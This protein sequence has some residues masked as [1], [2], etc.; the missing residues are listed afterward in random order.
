MRNYRFLHYMQVRQKKNAYFQRNSMNTESQY[1]L[2]HAAHDYE[3]LVNR[4]KR[5]ADSTSLHLEPFYNSDDLAHYFL[6]NEADSEGFYISAGIH[7]DEAAS[8]WGLL[9]WVEENANWIESQRCLI[10]PCLNPWG[11]I[12]NQRHN[13]KGEDLNRCFGHDQNHPL[14]Q[15]WAGVVGE[16]KFKIAISLHEDY[17]ARGCYI[18]ELSPPGPSLGERCLDAT[19]NIIPRDPDEDIEGRPAEK[20]LIR[21]EGDLQE[22]V[23]ELLEEEGGLPEAIELALNHAEW[24]LTFETPSE[25]SLFDR[26]RAQKAFLSRAIKD[27]HR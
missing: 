9:E 21:H 8:P 14:I 18:Y 27:A 20:A 10:F 2:Q 4:W 3:G 6:R 23:E 13:S 25:Y 24:S 5:I 22:L 11:L 19:E 15:S 17:D 16:A 12:Q 7:G 26:V 1:L